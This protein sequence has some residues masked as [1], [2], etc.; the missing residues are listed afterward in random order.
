MLTA[1]Q[2]KPNPSRL[3]RLLRLPSFGVALAVSVATLLLFAAWMFIDASFDVTLEVL[4]IDL[5]LQEHPG[6]DM[7]ETHGWDQLGPRLL[8]FAVLV[9][10]G[11][12]ATLIVFYRL[13][14]GSR[15]TRT[16]RAMFVA[17]ALVALW[18]TLILSSGELYLAGYRWRFRGAAKALKE[19]AAILLAHW[20]TAA[21]TLPFSGA[22]DADGEN[23]HFLM[24]KYDGH[25][26]Y[27][28]TERVGILIT[29]TD[30]GGLM[31]DY[32]V[33][34]KIEF[35]PGDAKPKSYTQ[36]VYNNGQEAFRS[37]YV[38]QEYTELEPN[39]FSVTYTTADALVEES[40]PTNADER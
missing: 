14:F 27:P 1:N 9:A 18:M 33:A 3:R 7:A 31:F 8:L 23:P 36:I 30:D 16:L 15:Q 32:N 28:M 34:E 22:F 19:D 24:V 10:I 39:W 17:V 6:I 11:L 21:G 25:N 2:S 5:G 12:L 13:Q 26:P 20:P 35:H 4:R 29:R 38:L 40:K 37:D